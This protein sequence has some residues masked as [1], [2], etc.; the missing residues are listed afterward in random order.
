VIGGGFGAESVPLAVVDAVDGLD[1]ETATAGV[2]LTTIGGGP[3][4]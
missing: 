4:S 3:V 1:A 2:E